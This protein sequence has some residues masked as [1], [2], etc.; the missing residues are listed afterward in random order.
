MIHGSVECHSSPEAFFVTEIVIEN[1]FIRG[2]SLQRQFV[3]SNME[4]HLASTKTRTL[5]LKTSRQVVST[6][7]LTY[8]LIPTLTLFC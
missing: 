4:V 2:L 6:A 5:A 7:Y 1:F 8:L 3:T